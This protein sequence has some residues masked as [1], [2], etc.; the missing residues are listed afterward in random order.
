MTSLGVRGDDVYFV[1]VDDAASNTSALLPPVARTADTA[2]GVALSE[3]LA[4]QTQLV[5]RLVAAEDV[6]IAAVGRLQQVRNG[7]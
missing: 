5:K 4:V 6:A 7:A 1:S 2:A 3:A